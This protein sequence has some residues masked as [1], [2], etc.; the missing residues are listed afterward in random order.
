V[1]VGKRHSEG[2]IKAINKSTNQPIEMEGGEVVITRGAVSNPKQYE[3]QGNQM[4]TREI[5]SKLN[6]DGGGVS[7]AE[8]GDIPDK[9]K[10]GCSH[11]ELGG[12]SMSTQD[13]VNLSESEYQK[14]RLEKGIEK[15][16]HDHYTTLSK[17][18]AGTITIQDALKEIAK[19]EMTIEEKYPFA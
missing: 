8:G 4:T 1:L 11:M 16:K 18:N 19:K 12:K 15:E 10:C 3:F 13:F 9:M 14:Y 6:V 7:F 2:G 17:L 5:L